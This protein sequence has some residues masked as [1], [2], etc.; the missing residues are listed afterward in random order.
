MENEKILLTAILAT[1]LFLVARFIEKTLSRRYGEADSTTPEDD[2]EHL[3]PRRHRLK[4]AFHEGIFVFVVCL[5]SL[6]LVENAWPV[7]QTTFEGLAS[8]Q[9]MDFGPPRVFTGMADF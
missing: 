8:G 4:A 6:A 9:A 5:A 3:A 1:A 2:M 7:L